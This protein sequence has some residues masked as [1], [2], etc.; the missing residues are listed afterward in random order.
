[1]ANVGDSRAL[2]SNSKKIEQMSRDHKPN[3]KGERRRIEQAGGSIYQNQNV[4]VRNSVGAIIEPPH[5]CLPGRLS[6]IP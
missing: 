4:I 3:D 1:M 2:I 5:R 6:V